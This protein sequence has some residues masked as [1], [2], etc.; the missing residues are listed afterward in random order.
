MTPQEAIARL[1][2]K[3][4]WWEGDPNAEKVLEEFASERT[5]TPERI[6]AGVARIK[7]MA[8]LRIPHYEQPA[9]SFIEE[10]VVDILT[11]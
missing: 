11:K 9:D 4:G 3:A 7:R 1:R 10:C 5:I 8:N 6:R 2:N